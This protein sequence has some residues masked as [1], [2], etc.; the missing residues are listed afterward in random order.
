MTKKESKSMLRIKW[1]KDETKAVA[2][3]MLPL[4]EAGMPVIQAALKAQEQALPARRL[5]TAGTSGTASSILRTVRPVLNKLRRAKVRTNGHAKKM[6]GNG[7]DAVP[8]QPLFSADAVE[9]EPVLVITR[10]SG[11]ERPTIEVS[12]LTASQFL[13]PFLTLEQVVE[14]KSMT[15]SWEEQPK[16][17]TNAA[18]RGD[19]DAHA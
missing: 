10:K 16:N 19:A 8:Q 3:A 14:L 15:A 17:E 12:R 11:S 18:G 13:P 4:I 1:R 5:R 6:N 2:Q 9:P 7:H